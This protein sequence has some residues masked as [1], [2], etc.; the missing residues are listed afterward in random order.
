MRSEA[1][2]CGLDVARVVRPA[3]RWPVGSVASIDAP[4]ALW[5]R[6]HRT[7]DSARYLY[8][9]VVAL[10]DGPDGHGICVADRKR[11]A[12]E[13][14]RM[15]PGDRVPGSVRQVSRRL[16]ELVRVGLIVR[17][18]RRAHQSDGGNFYVLFV[19]G[20]DTRTGALV[21]CS[22]AARMWLARDRVG[23]R[24]RGWRFHAADGRSIQ[25]ADL[26][27]PRRKC[28]VQRAPM[29]S[30]RMSRLLSS[31]SECSSK[32]HT[33]R[34]TEESERRVTS[35]SVTAGATKPD[36]FAAV[37]VMLAE[38][39]P[40]WPR[41][42][43]NYRAFVADFCERTFAADG[44]AVE[45]FDVV[46]FATRDKTNPPGFVVRLIQRSRSEPHLLNPWRLLND[47]DERAFRAERQ[48][49]RPALDAADLEVV[50]AAVAAARTERAP[51]AVAVEAHPTAH[52]RRLRIAFERLRSRVVAE[53]GAAKGPQLLFAAS[54]RIA[55]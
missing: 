5:D 12:S 26:H 17:G 3:I 13:M 46:A 54:C 33:G 36:R 39:H 45:W 44:D 14:R 41:F 29:T 47:D 53:I 7:A 30:H 37:E 16:S 8:A 10:A 24:S 4:A 1:R 42:E 15:F 23:L 18:E 21:G 31:E 32:T 51:D 6:L 19:L 52:E 43:Q 40:R 11:L 28:A 34:K 48:R 22:E 9:A 55:S 38:R 2:Q 35:R 27:W 20:V 25:F 50:N 49:N